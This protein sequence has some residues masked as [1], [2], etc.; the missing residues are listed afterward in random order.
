MKD[1]KC[2]ANYA[3]HKS[4]VIISNRLQR[5]KDL[6]LLVGELKEK[7]ADESH[8]QETLQRM[9]TICLQIK[10]ER[11]IGRQGVSLQWPVH[12]VMLI[13]E[14]LVNGTPPYSIPT[15]IQTMSAN[16]TGSEVNDLPSLDYVH[17]CRVVMQNINDK[18]SACSLVN[19]WNWHQ[20][21]TDVTTRR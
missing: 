8:P 6:K 7:L 1:D 20:I 12:I 4:I 11:T 5:L 16:I 2:K 19:S 17:K 10:R 21:F 13:C 3:V 15:N 14:L 18:L 9:S